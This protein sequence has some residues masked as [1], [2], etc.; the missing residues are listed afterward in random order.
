MLARHT[1]ETVQYCRVVITVE[2][3]MWKTVTI[4]NY[5]LM[6]FDESLEILLSLYEKNDD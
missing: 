4:I 3:G 6:P 5:P 1:R 2:L